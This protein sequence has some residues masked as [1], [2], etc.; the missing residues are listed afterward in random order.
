MIA[1]VEALIRARSAFSPHPVL[2][3]QVTR[4]PQGTIGECIKNSLDY[5]LT[6]PNSSIVSGWMVQPREQSNAKVVITQHY[7]VYDP[8][9][10]SFLDVTPYPAE[11]EPIAS[12]RCYVWDQQLFDYL[13]DHY[14]KAHRLCNLIHFEDAFFSIEG[15]WMRPIPALKVEHL[16][17]LKELGE[18]C[19][20]AP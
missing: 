13:K 9:L 1:A 18:T 16:I 15:E 14:S 17:E 7:F 11:S 6:H 12:Q 8:H 2:P 5:T 3:V 20:K 19:G 10:Q 4:C